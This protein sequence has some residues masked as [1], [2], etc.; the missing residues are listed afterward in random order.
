MTTKKDYFKP[1]C[2][3]SSYFSVL[4]GERLLNKLFILYLIKAYALA[5]IIYTFAEKSEMVMAPP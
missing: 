3:V 1:L 2:L 5:T 4:N